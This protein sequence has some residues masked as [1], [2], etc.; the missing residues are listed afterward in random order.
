MDRKKKNRKAAWEPDLEQ[1]ETFY[2]IAGY[3]SWGVP[4]GVTWEQAY[5]EGLMDEK[6][7]LRWEKLN[8]AYEDEDIPF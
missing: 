3:T 2:F 4:Y 7:K 5:E 6:E 8:E 1:D